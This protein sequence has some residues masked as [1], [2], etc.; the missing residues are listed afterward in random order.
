MLL[1]KETL[2]DKTLISFWKIE[3]T[4]DELLDKLCRKDNLLVQISQFG[5]EKRRLEYVATRV[6]L[7]ETLGEEKLIEHYPSGAPYITDNSFNIS[8]AHTG[9]YVA[10][11]LN[12]TKK[13]GID[14][15][16][17]G[18]RAVRVKNRFLSQNE[19]DFIVNSTEKTHLTLMWCAKETLYKIIDIEVIDFVTDLNIMPFFPYISGTIEAKENCTRLKKNYTLTYRVEPEICCSWT[20][21]N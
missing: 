11:I 14:I 16:K 6:L 12:P 19:L 13:V 20:V 7:K 9:E 3:E 8:I 5:S 4:L 15:E 1:S 17:I 2:K 10:I 21:E 18:D